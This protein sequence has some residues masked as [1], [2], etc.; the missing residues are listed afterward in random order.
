[1]LS[2]GVNVNCRGAGLDSTRLSGRSL[3]ETYGRL[4]RQGKPGELDLQFVRHRLAKVYGFNRAVE[5]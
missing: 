2:K 3:A 4:H 5:G 1:M